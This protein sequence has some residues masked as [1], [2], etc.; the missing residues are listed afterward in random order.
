MRKG[1]RE[2]GKRKGRR[3]GKWLLQF[4]RSSATYS[5]CTEV[6]YFIGFSTS[7]PHLR[8]SPQIPEDRKTDRGVCVL[9]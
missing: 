5:T 6:N 3:E 7:A 9:E 4:P 2:E 8:V 1:E